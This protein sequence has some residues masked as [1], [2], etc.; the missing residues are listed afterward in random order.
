MS[1]IEFLCVIVIYIYYILSDI[2]VC[3]YLV[4][5]AKEVVR[6]KTHVPIRGIGCKP[7]IG[8]QVS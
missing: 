1:F 8:A 2:C 5:V 7:V 4:R 3:V 6:P